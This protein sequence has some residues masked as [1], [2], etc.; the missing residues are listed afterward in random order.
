M[1]YILE[2]NV[3]ITD[4]MK[5]RIGVS[6]AALCKAKELTVEVLLSL[7]ALVRI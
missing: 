4:K 3:Y 7:D 6:T 1:I 2:R 5:V